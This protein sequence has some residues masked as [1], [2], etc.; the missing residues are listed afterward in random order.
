MKFRAAAPFAFQGPRFEVPG[1]LVP[2]KYIDGQWQP[3]QKLQFQDGDLGPS[4]IDNNDPFFSSVKLLLHFGGADASTTFTDSGPSGKTVG[5]A[6]NTQID[7]AQS[8]FGGSSGLFDGTG[9]WLTTPNGD[10][11]FQWGTGDFTWEAFVRF[12][13]APGT[14]GL[15]SGGNSGNFNLRVA[16]GSLHLYVKSTSSFLS[17]AWAPTTGVWYHV[18]CS[19]T[20]GTSRLFV[21]G[22]QLASGADA[23]NWTMNQQFIGNSG[24]NSEQLNGWLDELRITK[25]VGRYAA[26]FSPPTAAFPDQ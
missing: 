3:G 15:V 16:G 1:L 12:N 9:D 25:G 22:V 24:P 20:S 19:R 26:A 23:T 21:D 17:G 14:V 13:V 18:A 11:D 5:V 10:A 8:K 7:T 6:G 4:V 2:R